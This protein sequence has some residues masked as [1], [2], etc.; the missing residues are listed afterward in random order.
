MDKKFKHINDIKILNIC[1][2]LLDNDGKN[3]LFF[4][5]KKYYRST[6]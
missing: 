1:L 2:T 6:G 4:K 3:A 5:L